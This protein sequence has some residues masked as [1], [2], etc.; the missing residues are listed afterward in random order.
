VHI[1][2][3]L[4]RAEREVLEGHLGDAVQ[5]TG[6]TDPPDP[7]DYRVLVTGRPTP[8]LLDASDALHTL[9]IPWAGVPKP[10]TPL[11]KARPHLRV[12]NLHHNADATAE[13]AVS[14]MLAVAKNVLRLDREL[15][16]NDWTSRA[17]MD[18]SL[19]LRGRRAMVLGYGAIGRRV[20]EVCHALGM[21][22]TGVSRRGLPAGRRPSGPVRVVPVTELDR[23]LPD[24][25]VLLLCCPATPETEGLLDAARL[26][27]LPRDAVL[28]NVARGSVVDEGALFEALRGRRLFGAG[29]DVWYRYPTSSA[30]EKNTPPS[31]FDFQA[32]SNVVMSPH[33]GGHV[34]ETEAHR[35]A[36]LAE[37]L[38]AIA[39]GEEPPHRVDVDAGY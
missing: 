3:S 36:A 26:D 14:L 39:R 22:V 32:L 28:V 33:R 27:L 38:G 7:A 29:L 21:S 12:H 16:G 37:A 6:G 19:Q 10:T 2:P 24:A 20:A 34:R 5:L 11:L 13:L 15:R 1:S 23:H 9:I 35:M 25:D 17:R 31:R 18:R 8:E 30:A 4:G